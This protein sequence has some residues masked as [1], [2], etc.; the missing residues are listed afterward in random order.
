MVYKTIQVGM[1][2]KHHLFTVKIAI[3]YKRQG[4]FFSSNEQ[5]RA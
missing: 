2:W 4:F 1:F 5:G 3:I